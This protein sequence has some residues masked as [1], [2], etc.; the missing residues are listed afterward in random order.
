ML[1]SRTI[2][3]SIDKETACNHIRNRLDRIRT[4][5]ESGRITIASTTGTTLAY[6][7]DYEVSEGQLG[8]KLEYRTGPTIPVVL[9][10]LVRKAK[11]IRK[12]VSQYE[13]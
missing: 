13:I 1:T 7:S 3:L 2:Y 4:T 9:A 5:R 11:K 8:T 12:A 6:L 10:P